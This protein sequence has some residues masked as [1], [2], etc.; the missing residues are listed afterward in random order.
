[1]YHPPRLLT[2][3][4][5]VATGYGSL[6]NRRTPRLQRQTSPYGPRR[7]RI[8]AK[9]TLRS[10]SLPVPHHLLR[11]SHL[12]RIAIFLFG[13]DAFTRVIGLMIVFKRTDLHMRN[14]H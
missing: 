8:L 7:G 14:R 10:P 4:S 1:M 13:T 5:T 9:N 12:S 11:N 3:A 6:N 2:L